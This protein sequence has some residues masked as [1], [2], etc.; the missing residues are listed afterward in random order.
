MKRGA[1]RCHCGQRDGRQPAAQKEKSGGH[2]A[3]VVRDGTTAH[4][5]QRTAYG[6]DG[7]GHGTTEVPSHA[8]HDGNRAD[9]AQHPQGLYTPESRRRRP[10]DATVAPTSTQH[11]T[12]IRSLP[13]A[14]DTVTPYANTAPTMPWQTTSP[15]P[16]SSI[17]MLESGHAGPPGNISHVPS[18]PAKLS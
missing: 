15:T 10:S 12:A 18:A 4:E 11:T 9:H 13:I 16:R 2:V 6:V 1:R 3:G 14:A 7:G 8:R 5:G 17:M